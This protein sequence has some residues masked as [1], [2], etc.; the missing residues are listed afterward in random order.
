MINYGKVEQ[1]H[2]ATL[3]L[4]Q[5]KRKSVGCSVKYIFRQ[6]ARFQLASV[7]VLSLKNTRHDLLACKREGLPIAKKMSCLVG[8]LNLA[9]NERGN[10]LTQV[11][12]LQ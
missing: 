6:G 10:Q 8:E 9:F 2:F 5:E 11:S 7:D 12:L 3:N 4:E 1:R